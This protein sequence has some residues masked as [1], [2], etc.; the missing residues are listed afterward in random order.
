MAKV[1]VIMTTLNVEKHIEEALESVFKQTLKEIEV[2]CVDGKS[3]DSTLSI[4]AL[5]EKKYG[6]IRIIQQTRPGIGAAKNIGIEQ[7]EGEFITFLD[8]DDFYMDADALEKMY[9]AAIAEQVDICGAFRSVIHPNGKI[10]GEMLHRPLLAG[11]P[12]GRRFQYRDYQYDYHFHSYL[13]RREKIIHSDAR[14]AEIAAYDDTHFHV[15]AMLYAEMFYVVPVELYCYRLGPAYAWGPKKANDAMKGLIDQLRFSAENRLE[16]VHWIAVQR[17]N[18]EY[19]DVFVK[20]VLAG[21]VDLLRLLLEANYSIS[22]ELLEKVEKNPPTSF[23]LQPMLHM[24]L[25]DLGLEKSPY[26]YAPNY[27]LLPLRRVLERKVEIREVE[28]IYYQDSGEISKIYESFSFRLGRFLTFIP[29]KIRGGLRCLKEHGL[30]YTLRRV[31]EKLK[32]LS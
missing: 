30:L 14:F 31:G 16:I 28:H 25:R 24:E 17:I 32:I 8:A 26:E 5:Y 9:K 7:A 23:L 21:D 1:S 18:H 22:G 10:E 11:H 2:I 15:R 6:R 20:N 4:I 3:T 29:R 12:G 27:I 19:R 13:Y